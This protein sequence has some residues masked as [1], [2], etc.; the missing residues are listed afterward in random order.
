M[1]ILPGSQ[2]MCVQR[3]GRCALSGQSQQTSA[4]QQRPRLENIY[5]FETPRRKHI[6]VYVYLSLC[7]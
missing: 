3:G 1:W 7:V 6:P 5:Y 4:G 2:P